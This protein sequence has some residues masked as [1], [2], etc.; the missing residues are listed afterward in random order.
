M[1]NYL[2]SNTIEMIEKKIAYKKKSKSEKKI[3][4]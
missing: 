1:N 3:G 2:L 4:K